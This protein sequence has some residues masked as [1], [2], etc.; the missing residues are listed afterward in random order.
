MSRSME[1]SLGLLTHVANGARSLAEISTVSGLPKSTAHRLVGVLVE[2]GYLRVEHHRF[3]LGYRL[4]ALGELAREQVRLPALARPHMEAASASTQET[5][6]LGE[7]VGPDVIY[8]E[9]VEGGRGLQMK[10]RVGLTSRAATTAMGKVL[11][12][13]LP[14]EDWAPF[15]RQAEPRTPHTI[16]TLA[17]FHAELMAVRR[18]GFAFDRE[19]NE[20][21]ICCVAAAIRDA[22]GRAVA[23]VSLSGAVIFLPPERLEAMAVVIAACAEAISREI[24]GGGRS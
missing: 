3:F 13:S 2:H 4:L 19:E 12:A 7:L 18:H 20:V 24:G 5:I 10:S 22:A 11:I 9:K 1:K 17:G 21:G 14:E 15:F 6:H 23:A 16:D 8:L